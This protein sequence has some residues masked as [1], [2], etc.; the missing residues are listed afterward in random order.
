M[1]TFQLSLSSLMRPK[2]TYTHTQKMD[3]HFFL[4][5]DDPDPSNPHPLEFSPRFIQENVI[6]IHSAAV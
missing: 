5:D 4:N 6:T 2:R 1:S 3:I